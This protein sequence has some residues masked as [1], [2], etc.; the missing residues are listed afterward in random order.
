MAMM[1]LGCQAQVIGGGSGG[2]G[3]GGGNDTTTTGV[4]MTSGGGSDGGSALPNDGPAIA[5]LYSELPSFDPQSGSAV[6]TGGGNAIDPSSLYL[7]VS[8]SAQ[9]CAN[10]FAG[11]GSCATLSYQ[12]SIL[13][14]PSLQVLGSHSLNEIGYLS[15]SEPGGSGTC[16]GGGGSYWDGT[17][18]I[19]SIDSTHVTF[20]LAGTAQIFSFTPQGT[21]DG[22]YTAPR[23]F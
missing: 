2:S 16:S 18:D 9:A 19:T 14:P 17:I 23:C 22:T 15:V 3:G 7:F 11:S 10:P 4:V 1:I 8:N 6:C 5:M 21:A 13:L 12:L 20:T